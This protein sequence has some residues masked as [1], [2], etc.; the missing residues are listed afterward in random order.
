MRSLIDVVG[1]LG[2]GRGR[3]IIYAVRPFGAH[4]RAVVHDPWSVLGP[5]E[6]L[7]PFLE[8]DLAHEYLRAWSAWQPVRPSADAA[9]EALVAFAS[10]PLMESRL[11][12]LRAAGE[13]GAETAAQPQTDAR[14]AG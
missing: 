4:S 5:E 2:A 11:A 9:V 12:P 10:R 1:D 7:E 14:A 13:D 3:G 8:A 6:G